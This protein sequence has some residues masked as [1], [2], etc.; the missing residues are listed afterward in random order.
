MRPR[1]S[2]LWES[3]SRSGSKGGLTDR[4]GELA[5]VQLDIEPDDPLIRILESKKGPIEVDSLNLESSAVSALR[6]ARTKLIVPLLS[7]D[8]LVGLLA[9]EA[10]SESFTQRSLDWL[11][12]WS[13]HMA[14]SLR[15]A[16]LVE[17]RREEGERR[18]RESRDLEV[19]RLVQRRLLPQAA[20]SESGWQVSPYYSSADFVGGDFYDFM[21]LG[22]GRL[23]VVAGD[24]AG[25]GVSGALGMASVRSL[26]R[27]VSREHE[28]PAR[29]LQKV[30]NSLVEDLPDGMFVT[31]LYLT[32]LP[33]GAVRCAN[34]GHNPPMLLGSPEVREIDVRGMPLG[35]MPGSEYQDVDITVQPDE[36][37]FVY[38]DGLLEARSHGSMLGTSGVTALLP[39][40]GPKSAEAVIQH[41]ID[42]LLQFTGRDWEQDD[43]ITLLAILRQPEEV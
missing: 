37:L 31:C 36:A 24:V 5:R 10:T 40:S 39:R 43:D 25:K 14:A 42:G 15:L 33:E 38:S 26:L 11:S 12:R 22:G 19:A 3:I 29:A 8:G 13:S 30:N 17:Q 16:Q 7:P 41:I 21:D 23:G 27:Q 2:D 18:E 4:A 34:A 20:V 28:S 9:L 32:L 1:A 6:D 35:M